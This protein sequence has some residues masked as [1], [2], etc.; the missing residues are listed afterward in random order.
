M[1]VTSTVIEYNAHKKRNWVYPKSICQ[2][3]VAGS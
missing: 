1:V 3:T 2:G